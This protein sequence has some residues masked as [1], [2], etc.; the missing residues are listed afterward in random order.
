LNQQIRGK[1]RG[2]T[3]PPPAAAPM[4]RKARAK[5][6]QAMAEAG[7]DAAAIAAHLNTTAKA[8][9]RLAAAAGLS[10]A[11]GSRTARVSFWQRRDVADV[12]A[13]LAAESGLSR[14]ALA[15]RAHSAV[16]SDIDAA[17]LSLGLPAPASAKRRS[18]AGR[19]AR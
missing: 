18:A 8:I 14:S 4:G 2:A 12:V 17:R 3:A 6:L 7:R 10:L 19:A 11:G 15:Q 5:Q 16:F 13:R 1:P 9:N